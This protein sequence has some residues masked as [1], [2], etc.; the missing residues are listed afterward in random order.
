MEVS[1]RLED[2]ARDMF[3]QYGWQR[4]LRIGPPSPYASFSFFEDYLYCSFFSFIMFVGL[5]RLY[6]S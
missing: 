3:I 2:T 4:N 5:V 6:A 1:T